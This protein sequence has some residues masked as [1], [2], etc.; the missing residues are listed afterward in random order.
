MSGS[1]ITDGF[2][3]V[4]TNASAFGDGNVSKDYRPLD[5][6]GC[7]IV[8]QPQRRTTERIA[9]GLNGPRRKEYTFFLDM[10][11]KASGDAANDMVRWLTFED[12]VELELQVNEDV[13]DTVDMMGEIRLERP[14]DAAWEY[15]GQLWYRT[16]CEVDVLKDNV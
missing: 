16:F 15:G 7:V 6:S 9:Y 5:T 8:V 3:T 12:Q 1:A 14:R 4:F 11:M 2:V 13:N 10:W